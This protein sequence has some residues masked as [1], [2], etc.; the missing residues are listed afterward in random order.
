MAADKHLVLDVSTVLD[1]WLNPKQA[2]ATDEIF[3]QAPDVG[4]QLWVSA[5]SIANIES[6]TVQR[7]KAEGMSP[8]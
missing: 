8:V 6:V 2:A 4:A 1:Q 7:F 5:D 3:N